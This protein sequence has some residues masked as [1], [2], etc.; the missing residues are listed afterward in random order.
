MQTGIDI[1]KAFD[2]LNEIELSPFLL[3][4]TAVPV[5]SCIRVEKAEEVVKREL[6]DKD[7]KKHTVWVKKTI[8]QK[9]IQQPAYN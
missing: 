8:D 5:A 9:D 2:I 4:E 1:Q 6:K 7:G 3:P